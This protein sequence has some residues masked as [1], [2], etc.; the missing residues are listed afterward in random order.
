M[1]TVGTLN[2]ALIATDNGF[3]ATLNS[4]ASKVNDFAK[5][6][7]KN[8]GAFINFNA[9]ILESRRAISLLA[10][11]AGTSVAPIMHLIHSFGVFGSSAGAAIAS[12]LIIKE[13]I[14]AQTEALKKS[15][16]EANKFHAAWNDTDI[17]KIG[18]EL[19]R[20]KQLQMQLQ[21][22]NSGVLGAIRAKIGI[23]SRGE[24]EQV[25]SEI[26]RKTKLYQDLREKGL[27]TQGEKH[28]GIESILS[29]VRTGDLGTFHLEHTAVSDKQ[30]ENTNAISKLTAAIENV[31]QTMIQ[32]IKNRPDSYNAGPGTGIY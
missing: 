24:L 2:T 3:S 28:G 6:V 19:T 4:G 32:I 11:A 17:H 22:E 10:S 27:L 31:D 5:N 14:E 13:V 25:T 30:E 20:L 7:N 23:D 18:D 8:T 21:Y 16:D 26:N 29:T 15:T 1:A 9:K 12:F